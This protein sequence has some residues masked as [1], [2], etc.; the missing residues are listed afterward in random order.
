MPSKVDKVP[1]R[2]FGQEWSEYLNAS[3]GQM[4]RTL[5]LESRFRPLAARIDLDTFKGIAPDYLDFYGK[6]INPRLSRLESEHRM[7]TA[8]SDTNL[9]NRWG[10]PLRRAM[11]DSDPEAAGLIN[12]LSMQAA[13]DLRNRGI[14]DRYRRD[15]VQDLRSAQASRGTGYGIGD[16][17][18]EALL[19]GSARLGLED[20]ARANAANVLGL[21]NAQTGGALNMLNRGNVSHMTNLL[22]MAH[23]AAGTQLLDPQNPYME[24][25]KSGNFQ[26][27]NQRAIQKSRNRSALYSAGIQALGNIAGGG[28]EGWASTWG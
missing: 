6:S 19:T 9:L 4:A 17:S 10:A 18:A 23:Q 13:D 8:E 22:P 1:D 11:L 21:R 26:A 12:Q 5:G 14:S 24:R 3:E 25:L 28:M 2:N 7:R 16:L 15:L 27:A 20:R